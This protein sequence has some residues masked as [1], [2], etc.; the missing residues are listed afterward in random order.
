MS[1]NRKPKYNP[2]K[3]HRIVSVP[4]N[5]WRLQRFGSA[6]GTKEFDPW[7]NV[8]HATDY[9]KAAFALKQHDEQPKPEEV[10]V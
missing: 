5:F 9:I 3:T 1:T 2:A 7:V 4:N 8:G 10:T 6:A